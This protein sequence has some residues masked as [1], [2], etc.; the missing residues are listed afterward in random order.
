MTQTVE[1]G[2]GDHEDLA[3]LV[4]H[5]LFD[6]AAAELPERHS[7]LVDDHHDVGLGALASAE[8]DAG[9]SHCCFEQPSGFRITG[10]LLPD[11]GRDAVAFG[12]RAHIA[13]GRCLRLVGAPHQVDRRQ[14]DA[15]LDLPRQGTDVV[16]VLC[17]RAVIE[18]ELVE[19]LDEV[20]GFRRVGRC[21]PIE[22]LIGAGSERIADD[23]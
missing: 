18:Q 16:F 8:E 21:E 12:D 14:R 5:A 7:H 19:P 1:F 9:R 17:S 23:G 20:T 11:L 3:D 22:H 2:A 10:D 6:Q 4:D 15:W 13:A